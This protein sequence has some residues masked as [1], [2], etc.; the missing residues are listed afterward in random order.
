M[1]TTQMATQKP[2]VFQTPTGRRRANA[3]G[4]HEAREAESGMNCRI[5]FQQKQ[6]AIMHLGQS[7]RSPHRPPMRNVH[8]I[9][10]LSTEMMTTWNLGLNS[11]AIIICGIWFTTVTTKSTTTQRRSLW[12]SGRLLKLQPWP[13]TIWTSL[14]KIRK[15]IQSS[16]GGN[17]VTRNTVAASQAPHSMTA[18]TRS[19]PGRLI[20]RPH[21]TSSAV[22]C[23]DTMVC[24]ESLAWV[25]ATSGSGGAV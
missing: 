20:S 10:S 18:R 19:Q 24:G 14:R 25:A 1:Y 8:M 23:C 3:L 17:S 7:I 4:M 2:Q 12:M 15:L 22:R 6:C 13:Q 11:L 21:Y 5:L 9:S 16:P